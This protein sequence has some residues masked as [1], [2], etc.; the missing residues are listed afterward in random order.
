MK[1]TIAPGRSGADWVRSA[2]ASSMNYLALTKPVVVALLLTTT[3]AAMIVGAG[4][5][6]G[7]T[8]VLWTMLGG[9]M[10]AGGASA[11]NQ[12]IERDLDRHMARTSRRPLPQGKIQPRSAFLFALSISTIGLLVLVAKVNWLTA[13]MALA[14]WVY[15]VIFY[16][17]ILKPTTPQNIVVGGGAGAIPPLVG[18]A[19]ATGQLS[20]PAFFLFAII[21]FWTPPHFWALALLKRRDYARAG[22][23]MLPVVVGEVET[24]LHILL[25]SVQLVALSILLPVARVGG[26]IYL[27]AALSLGTGF[28]WYAWK[29]YRQ[30][31]NQ[32]AWKMYRYSSTYLALIFSALVVDTLV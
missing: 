2:A 16:S 15:Y 28:I 22:V 17:L 24:R 21:F 5:W 20:M 23:P 8:L 13:L 12:Y 25:Y 11:L 27:L 19:A 14:G 31:G 18:W 1:R 30:G 6:P 26:G 9:A 29:L 4:A 3:L 32:T 7:G 10:T